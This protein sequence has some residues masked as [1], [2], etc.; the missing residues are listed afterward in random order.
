[1]KHKLLVI[2][3]LAAGIGAVYFFDKD[4]GEKRRKMA[5][6]ETR[7]LWKRTKDLAR[8]YSEEMQPRLKEWS[9]ELG[10]QAQTLSQQGGVK[11]KELSKNGWSPSA[12]FL[13]ASASAIAFYGAARPG[14]LGGL[15]RMVSLGM[16]TRALLTTK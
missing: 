8:D 12:R 9:K 6:K 4:E 7:R 14:F 5:R 3:T 10:A 13:G 16:F 11:V 2:G 15:L 1:M